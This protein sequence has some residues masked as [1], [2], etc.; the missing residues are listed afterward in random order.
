MRIVHFKIIIIYHILPCYQRTAINCGPLQ[1][2]QCKVVVKSLGCSRY[3]PCRRRKTTSR[4]VDPST[5]PIFQAEC[6]PC[7]VS[8][9]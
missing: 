3:Q 2:F 1:S 7:L 6:L 4:W 8:F 9:V 5:R